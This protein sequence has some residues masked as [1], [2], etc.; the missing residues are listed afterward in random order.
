M[1]IQAIFFDIDGTL[2]SFKTLSIPLSTKAAIN[3]LRQKGIKVI[4]STGRAYCDM[5]NLE[6][7]EFDGYITANGACCVDSKGETISKHPIS[8]ESME[9]LAL[10]LD[11]NPFTCVFVTEKG[12]Y[13]NYVSDMMRSICKLINIPIPP[14]K[15]LAEILTHDIFQLDAYIDAAMETE[16]FAYVL[17][18]CI[19]WR[20]HTFFADINPKHCNKA[21]GM[22]RFLTHFGIE[23]EHTMA[24][25]DGENDISILK[26]AAIG[27]A[28]GNAN[29]DVKAAADYV[30][31]SV[32]DNGVFNALRRFNVLEETV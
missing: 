17:T 11:T 31:S 7:L 26:H 12:N 5:V 3:Q 15:P 18:D 21:T 1:M 32:D 16:L 9:R 23:R 2:V 19:A 20:W 24:F 30:T 6:D 28:M 14:V 25:G 27:V 4:I 8:K 10:Y 22:D 13:V 29:D